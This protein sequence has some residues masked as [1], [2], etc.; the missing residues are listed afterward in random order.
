MHNRQK[1]LPLPASRSRRYEIV[2]PEPSQVDRHPAYTDLD[3]NWIAAGAW[4]PPELARHL[5]DAAVEFAIGPLPVAVVAG[6]RYRIIS[7][8]RTWHAARHAGVL[9]PLVIARGVSAAQ[10]RTAVVWDIARAIGLQHGSDSARYAIEAC[11]ELRRE[12]P[13]LTA[14]LPRKNIMC[15]WYGLTPDQ[16]RPAPS[17]PRCGAPDPETRRLDLGVTD[18]DA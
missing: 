17:D 8:L 9:V 11:T 18:D 16:V 14:A 6:S 2:Q 7:G 1:P 15:R 10:C 4:P 12:H 13:D 3:Q 5:G